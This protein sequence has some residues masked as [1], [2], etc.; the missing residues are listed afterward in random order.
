VACSSCASDKA[1]PNNHPIWRRALWIALGINAAMF[2]VEMIAGVA[3][4]SKALQADA[5]DFLGDAA[6]YAISLGV[7]GMALAWRA[8][9]AFFKGATLALLGLYVLGVTLWAVWHGRTPEAEV[10]GIVGIAALI[11]NAGVAVM[12]YR[13]RSGDANM[14]SVWI[15][16]RN[17]AIGNLA[18]VLAAA[19]VF[20][21]GSAWP[22][23]VVATIMAALGLFGGVQIMRQARGELMQS[24]ARMKLSASAGSR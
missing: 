16:S 14:R 12:L 15:C 24:P 13:F 20:G 1:D 8:R 5:L 3:G 10:M 9:A 4:G 21:T 11:A 23:L 7:A 19:G 22:D 18:V 17:D 6:N 2:L